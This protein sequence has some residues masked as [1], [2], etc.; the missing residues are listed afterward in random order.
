MSIEKKIET[1]AV[2]IARN[3]YYQYVKHRP[4]R[5]D[6]FI[7]KK[8]MRKVKTLQTLMKTMESE[9]MYIKNSDIISNENLAFVLGKRLVLEQ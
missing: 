7:S 8:G 1:D 2:E 6:A 9:G 4:A 5:I 3:Y